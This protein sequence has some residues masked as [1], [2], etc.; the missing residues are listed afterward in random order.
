MLYEKKLMKIFENIDHFRYF[1]CGNFRRLGACVTCCTFGWTIYIYGPW[2]K[3]YWCY[4]SC[5]DE[6]QKEI[7]SIYRSMW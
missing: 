1:R 7:E 2:G 5:G 6:H 4:Y 3:G